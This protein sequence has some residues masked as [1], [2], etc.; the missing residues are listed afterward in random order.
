M[1][2]Q[3]KLVTLLALGVTFTLHASQTSQDAINRN[4]NRRQASGM[5]EPNAGRWRTW[6]ISSGKDY[7]VPPPPE[8]QN[9]Q[10]EL[11]TIREL[12]HQNNTQTLEQIEFWDAGAPPYRW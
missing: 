10:G 2:V 8:N 5:I 4:G 7:L 3:K 11:R 12:V 6:V 1:T 9:T